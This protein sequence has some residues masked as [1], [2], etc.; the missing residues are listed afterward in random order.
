MLHLPSGELFEVPISVQYKDIDKCAK[1][2]SPFDTDE[3]GFDETQTDHSKLHDLT[4]EGYFAG[5]SG[6]LLRML[7]QFILYSTCYKQALSF[8][9]T[10]V[11]LVLYSY[12]FVKELF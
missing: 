5:L 3:I 1:R 9:L 2:L 6:A 8:R 12:A 11:Q 7:L 10:F 4:R